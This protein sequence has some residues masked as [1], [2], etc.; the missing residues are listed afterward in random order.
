MSTSL[1]RRR[2]LA[3]CAVGLTV[4]LAGCA[5]P[6]VAMFV[7]R[8]PTDRAIAER[9]TVGPDRYE[10]HESLVASA[11]DGGTTATGEYGPPFE[12]DRP[13]A[14]DGA[15]Y[16]FEWDDTGDTES[17]T[18]YAVT[19]TVYDDDRATDIDF[20]E[21]PAIDQDRLRNVQ[22]LIEATEAQAESESDSNSESAEPR[23]LRFQHYYTKAEREASAI[24]PDPE[25]DVIAVNGRPTTVA[26]EPTTVSLSVYRYTVTERAP[27]LAAFGGDLSAN[28][29]VALT[30][31]SEAERDF[32]EAVSSEGS[33]YQGSFGDDREEAFAKIADRLVAE[34]A[35]FVENRAGEWL[36]TYDGETYWV[37][38][39]FVRMEEYADRLTAVD[40]L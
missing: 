13:V 18:E 22:R 38:I 28:H 24:V 36:V 17:R 34:P 11:V 5:D 25:Y 33:Y 26:V 23:R 27:T 30:G 21:L 8:V 40:S 29:R 3:G 10:G 4:G 6:D 39:D 1:S 14:Y 31:L 19:L 20:T 37:E 32:F 16:D 2:L 35:L 15:V 9:A 12:P 7:E